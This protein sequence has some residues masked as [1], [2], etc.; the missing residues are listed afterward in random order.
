MVKLSRFELAAVKRTGASVRQFRRRLRKIDE[1]IASLE[2][3]KEVLKKTIDAWEEPVRQ[4]T[5][6]YTS[7]QI[8]SGKEVPGTG[9]WIELNP[10]SE[11]EVEKLPINKI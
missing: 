2:E 8:L 11:E 1:Q 9:D 6:G 4:L 5:G 3:E 7:L 10:I